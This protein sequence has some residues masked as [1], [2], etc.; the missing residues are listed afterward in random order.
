MKFVSLTDVAK[1]DRTVASPA[2]CSSLPYVGLEHIEKHAGTF[3]SEFMP[4]AE[5]LLA[6]KFKFSPRH[7]LYGKLRPYLNKVA[8]PEFSGVCTTEIL[9][10]LPD[11]SRLERGYLYGLLLSPAF[12]RWASR[13]TS[14][15]NLPRLDP[16]LLAEY[17]IPLPSLLEQKRIAAVLEMTD[18]VRRT[19]RYAR[20]LSDTFL[21][22]TFIE[23]FG[24]MT[25]NTKGWDREKFSD[26][27]KLDRG[28]SKHRPRNASHLYG[29]KYPFLQTGDIANCANY[30]THHRQTYSEE[31]L[32]QSKLWPVE[33]LCITIAANIA[34]TGIL[35]YPSCFPDSVVGFVPGEN[36]TTEFVQYWLSFLQ[37]SL[38]RTAPESAQKNINLE[39]LRDLA[40]PLPPL[41]LQKKFADIVRRFEKLRT[42]HREAE[43]Q[44]E[45]L[46]QTLLHR[47]FEG[48]LMG[49]VRSRSVKRKPSLRAS[50]RTYSPGVFYR[51]AA[52]EAYVI[53]ALQGDPYLG[54]T[55]LEKIDH[56]IEYHC[57]VDLERYPVRDAAGPD[58]YLSRMKL[59][60]LANKRNWFSAHDKKDGSIVRYLPKR[61]FMSAAHKGSQ[62]I[63]EKRNAVDNLLA[64]M[65]P[66]DTKR[67]EI[68]AT[69]YAAW[70]DFLLNDNSPSDEE[71][72][73]DVLNNWRPEKQLI[74]ERRWLRALKWMR[75]NA[76]VPTGCGKPVVHSDSKCL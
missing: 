25:R 12:V 73:R 5:K 15:A 16:K 13:N 69:L 41:P 1:V 37:A 36:V 35:T 48:A 11:E 22:S 44:S 49:V 14:G 3:I 70:N 29:G 24:E 21:Q 61:G 8:L 54:R 23:M 6:T 17:E 64:L 34:K 63:G 32:K 66:L 27:G 76:L 46:F 52:I 58:D 57:G 40:V 67:C 74:P 60:H 7:I 42:L 30:I 65:R 38:E 56:L 68:I 72:V 47:A 18:R 10:L 53:N 75:E 4:K 39:I 62:E 20:Q 50:W 45:H 19:R 59:E 51:R 2:E 31:G 55:K 9:P 71:I 33:T 28:R 26:L 43:R